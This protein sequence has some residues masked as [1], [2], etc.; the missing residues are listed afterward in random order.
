MQVSELGGL[1]D[2]SLVLP[3]QLIKIG[4]AERTGEGQLAVQQAKEQAVLLRGVYEFGLAGGWDFVGLDESLDELFD[5]MNFLCV[6]N[7]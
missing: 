2:E 1:G 4:S 5:L 7:S 6:V 3:E